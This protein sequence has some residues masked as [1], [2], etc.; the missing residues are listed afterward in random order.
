[1]VE[2]LE[3]LYDGY[4]EDPDLTEE[5]VRRTTNADQADADDLAEE[6]ALNGAY[7]NDEV[8]EIDSVMDAEEDLDVETDI[9]DLENSYAKMILDQCQGVDEDNRPKATVAVSLTMENVL[10]DTSRV[11]VQSACA[12]A[13]VTINSRHRFI[14]VD[15][16]FAS[17]T[18]N[19]LKL[20]YSHLERYGDL[21]NKQE[22]DDDEIPSFKFYIVPVSSLGSCFISAVEPVF[23]ALTSNKPG[24]VPN[25]VRILFDAEYVDFYETDEVDLEDIDAEAQ[26]IMHEKA[27]TYKQAEERERERAEQEAR[28]NAI[29]ENLRKKGSIS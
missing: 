29:I 20:I 27:E 19:E 24:E 13:P 16:T 7:D 23:W 2:E 1:M 21:L 11:V 4:D 10:E 15:M 3:A 6:A 25:Q 12:T 14:E 9:E 17:P 8:P 28:N 22:P 5:L 26:R 18:A